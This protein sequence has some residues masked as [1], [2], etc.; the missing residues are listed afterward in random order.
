[1]TAPRSTFLLLLVAACLALAA[2]PAFAEPEE[3]PPSAPPAGAVNEIP[4]GPPPGA[5]VEEEVVEH[6]KA[7][8]G[9]LPDTNG[10]KLPRVVGRMPHETNQALSAWRLRIENVVTDRAFVGRVVDQHPDAGTTL[11]EGE[12]VTLVVGVPSLPSYHHACVP[13]IEKLTLEAGVAALRKQGFDIMLRVAESYDRDKGIVLAQA[14]RPASIAPRGAKVVVVVGKGGLADPVVPVEPAPPLPVAPLP[15]PVEEPVMPVAP[16]PP[17]GPPSMPEGPPPGVEP[18]VVEQPPV[19]VEPPTPPAP[20]AEEPPAPTPPAPPAEEPPAPMPPAEE[21]IPP[22]P[23]TEEPPAPVPVP[24]PAPVEPPKPKV[25]LR[26]PVLTAPGAG[27]SYPR[28]FGSTFKWGAVSGAKTFELEMQVEAKD[29]TWSTVATET[30]E[31]TSFRP[32]RLEAGRYRW[33]VRAMAEGVEGTWSEYRRL[34]LY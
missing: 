23:P 2:G 22:M 24:V 31:G 3:S 7:A 14:P 5:P 28:A 18:P 25:T 11:A 6:M 29:G 15:A 20:P 21:P 16:E 4:D 12:V 32:K 30:V 1:M 8:P 10:P 33:R 34:Y 13:A 27:E 17:A 26:V 9:R 19:P